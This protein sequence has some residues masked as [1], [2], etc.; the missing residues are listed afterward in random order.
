MINPDQ[1]AA[2]T[3][4]D[5][6]DTAGENDITPEELELLDQAGEDEEEVELRRAELDNTDADGTLLNEQSSH[7]DASGKDLDVPG[8]GDDDD[9]EDI[10]EEDEENNSYSLKD[11]DA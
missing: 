4:D 5:I 1:Q 11:G 3:N 8:S 10:G 9:N 7:D 2:A 6:N